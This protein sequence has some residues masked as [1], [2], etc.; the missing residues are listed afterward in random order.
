MDWY[1]YVESIFFTYCRDKVRNA[2]RK[3]SDGMKRLIVRSSVVLFM[4]YVL[5]LLLVQKIIV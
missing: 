3:W 2:M 5:S 1:E 4:F